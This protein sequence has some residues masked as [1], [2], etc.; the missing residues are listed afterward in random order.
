DRP[1]AVQLMTIHG[2]KGLEFPVVFV[3]EAHV[4]ARELVP[5]VIWRPGEGISFTL[6][7]SEDDDQRPRPGFYR[8]LQQLQSLDDRH[9]HLR[10]FY[11]AV[12]GAGDYL[13]LPGDDSNGEGWLSTVRNAHAAGALRDIEVRPAVPRGSVEPARRWVRSTVELPDLE[14]PYTPPLLLRP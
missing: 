5:A 2:A 6:E 7:R 13:S 11:V 12:T 10:L 1:N 3:P 9:E 14:R 8:Y 4:T